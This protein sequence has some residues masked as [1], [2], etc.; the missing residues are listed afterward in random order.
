ML[1]PTWHRAYLVRFENALR[2]IPGCQDVAVPFWDELLTYGDGTR[3]PIPSVLT[4]PTFSLDGREDNPLY[5]Y[6]L[7]QKLGPETGENRGAGERYTKHAGYEVR[8]LCF[9]AFCIR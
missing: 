8:F 7:Q 2:S 3:T 5:S 4:T 9:F 6:K 1:F